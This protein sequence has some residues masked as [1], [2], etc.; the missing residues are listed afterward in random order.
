MHD[1]RRELAR[2]TLQNHLPELRL[3]AGLNGLSAAPLASACH[4]AMVADL[5]ENQ[6]REERRNGV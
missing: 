5:K 2:P 4:K 3:D 6:K 1:L